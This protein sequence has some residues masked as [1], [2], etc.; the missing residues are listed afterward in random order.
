MCNL[1]FIPSFK[2]LRVGSCSCLIVSALPAT[3]PSCGPPRLEHVLRRLLQLLLPRPDQLPPLLRHPV[4]HSPHVQVARSRQGEQRD[5]P[6]GD[7][8]QCEREHAGVAAAD[9]AAV[10]AVCQDVGRVARKRLCGVP[11]RVRGLKA[12][13]PG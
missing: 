8:A 5:E 4:Y 6:E 2:L 7:D 13:A 12:D 10:A 3:V 11:I 1:E 9:F